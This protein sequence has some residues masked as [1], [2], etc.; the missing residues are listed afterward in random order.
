MMEHVFFDFSTFDVDK[1]VHS[2]SDLL[3]FVDDRL[4]FSYLKNF[5]PKIAQDILNGLSY[6]HEN[7]VVHRDLKP[8]NV[9]VPNQHYLGETEESIRAVQFAQNCDL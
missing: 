2:L 5:Q 8:D 9:L 6:L 4:D 7:G 3:R 1:K